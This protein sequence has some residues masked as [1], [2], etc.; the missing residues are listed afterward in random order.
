MRKILILTLL[1]LLFAHPTAQARKN[2][3]IRSDQDRTDDVKPEGTE[4]SEFDYEALALLSLELNPDENPD[5]VISLLKP[6]E[7]DEDNKSFIFYSSLGLA[8]KNREEFKEAIAA[9]NRAL[10][11]NPDEPSAQYYLGIA[12][13]KNNDFPNALKYILKSSVQKPDHPGVIKWID[14]LTKELDICKVPDI[15]NMK[16]V[17]DKNIN[18][19]REEKDDE[20]RLR[21]YYTPAGGRIQ[22][23]SVDDKI[24]S[25]GIDSNTKSP[26]DYIII[27]TD[28]NGQFE[29]VINSRGRFGVPA[30]AYT[31]K[32]KRQQDVT[33]ANTDDSEEEED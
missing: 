16:M 3:K 27:D 9:Y 19:N 30:W 22:V 11:I 13:Y 21:I 26:V 31:P 15:S 5:L 20:T 1:I 18:V 25:Y 32:K 2:M 4:I 6:Y 14:K 10:E 24:Y 23:L 12:Y 28:G 29:K 17:I 7:N 8:Y 33:P